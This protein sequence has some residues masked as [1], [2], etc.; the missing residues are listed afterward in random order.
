VSPLPVAAGLGAAGA[1]VGALVLWWERGVTILLDL[2][3]AVAAC[4]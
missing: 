3:A 1:V 4:F 2:G